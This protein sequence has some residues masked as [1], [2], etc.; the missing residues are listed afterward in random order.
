[1]KNDNWIRKPAVLLS[2]LSILGLMTGACSLQHGDSD[3]RKPYPSERLE[4]RIVT[5]SKTGEI[6]EV[7]DEN[8][9]RLERINPDSREWR[10]F[11]DPKNPRRYTATILHT[12]SSPGCTWVSHN[13]WLERVC[14]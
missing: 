5:D 2:S 3:G 9:K 7:R 6:I 10:D 1:M 13:G 8:N 14:D 4:I 11:W 12:H